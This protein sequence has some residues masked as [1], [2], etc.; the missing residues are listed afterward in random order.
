MYE[1]QNAI[2]L[3]SEGTMDKVIAL[4]FIYIFKI[5]LMY[6]FF[7]KKTS[8]SNKFSKSFDG[9]G[10]RAPSPDQPLSTAAS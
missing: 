10:A 1:I 6:K 9:A 2:M 7:L 5:L 8:I 4:V 3:K